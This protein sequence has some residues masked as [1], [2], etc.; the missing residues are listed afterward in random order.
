MIAEH[1][2][3]LLFTAPSALRAIENVDPEAEERHRYDLSRVESL[4]LAGERLSLEPYHW[5]SDAP[6]VPVID[7]WWQTET[8]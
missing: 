3:K 6:G 7:Y 8:G 2:A 1:G 5:A 4:F